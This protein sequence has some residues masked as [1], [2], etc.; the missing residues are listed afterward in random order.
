[1]TGPTYFGDYARLTPEKPALIRA[2]TG[3]VLSYRQLD[4]RSNRL[5]QYLYSLG[6]RYGD[7]IALFMENNA[8]LF[9]VCWAAMRSGLFV[10]PI[11]RF[12]TT[13]EAAYIV[14]D[15][16]A[17]VIVSSWALR[18]TVTGLAALIPNCPTRLMVDGCVD[19]WAAFE[20]TVAAY[21]AERLAEEWMGGTMMYSSGTTGQPK[22]ILRQQPKVST[23]QGHVFV[24]RNAL[25]TFC[26]LDSSSTFLSTAPLYH[27]APLGYSTT[28]H[29]RGGTVVFM[30]KFDPLEALALIERHRV[31]HTQWVPTMFVRLLRL[32]DEER[33]RYDLSSMKVAVHAAAPCP[34]EVKQKMIDWWGPIVLEYYGGS[35]GNGITTIDAH[36]WLARPGS[37]GRPTSGSHLHICD[38]DGNELPAGERGT[39]YFE[40]E[41]IAFEYLND[42]EKTRASRHPLH[43]NWSAIGDVG[44]VDEEGYLYLTDRKSFMI[45]SG[46][47]NIYPQAIENALALHPAVADVAVIGVPSAEMGEDVKAI[48]QPA[49]GYTPSPRLAEEIIEYLRGKVARYMVPRSLDF[50]EQLPR[51]PTGKLNKRTLVDGYRTNPERKSLGHGL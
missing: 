9:D 34:V 43:E 16:G 5:A 39:I 32:S 45:I 15:C 14:N 19:G 42:P 38:D 36:E 30:D 12:L 2:A 11:N 46:G 35:E 22:G 29:M 13:D 27:S 24:E 31:T 47:V 25:F 26:G 37:V 44:Y 3:E 21:P 20:D 17:R 48:V 7:R 51:T 33:S 6:L 1:M 10:V 4:E 18:D 49:P 40:R 50:A 23:S 8:R 28:L 41:Q